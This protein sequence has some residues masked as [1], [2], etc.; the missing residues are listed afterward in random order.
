M[1]QADCLSPTCKLRSVFS[2]SPVAVSNTNKGPISLQI[3]GLTNGETVR[4]EKFLD[5]NRDGVLGVG[6]ELMQSFLLTD[7]QRSVIGGITNRN[8]P[9]DTTPVDGAIA[10]EVAFAGDVAQQLVG[11]YIF[12]L[13]SPTGRFLAI[14]RLF[15]VT[16]S[17]Y[18]QSFSGSVQCNGTN[19]PNVVVMVTPANSQKDSPVAGVV[20]DNSGHYSI[21]LPVGA[22][23]FFLFKSNFVAD[24]T[25]APTVDLGAGVSVSTNLTFLFPTTRTISGRVVDAG[26]SCLGLPGI[27]VFCQSAAS[28]IANGFTDAG[29]N[30]SVRVTSSQWKV[31][32]DD[33]GLSAYGYLRL[34]NNN[35][36]VDTSSGSVSGVTVALPK[37]TALVYGSVKDDQNRPIAGLKLYADDNNSQ[38]EGLGL[39]DQNGKY[40]VAVLASSWYVSPDNT[41][42]RNYIFTQG[43]SV[44][45]TSGQA[46]QQNFSGTIGTN[47]ISGLVQNTGN[48]PV[49]GVGVYGYATI[50]G[51]TYNQYM[52]TD[53]SGYYSLNV[54]NGNWNVGISCSGGND[55][56]GS[57][58]YQC[59][60]EQSATVANNNPKVNFT[61]QACASVQVTT[62]SQLP[63]GQVGSSYGVQFQAS[64]CN[65]PFSWAL[66]PGSQSLPAGMNLSSDGG[67]SGTPGVSGTFSFTVRVTSNT[68]EWADQPFSVT[69]NSSPLQVMTAS[70]P[71]GTSGQFY[72]QA[73]SASGGSPPYTWSLSPGSANPPPGLSLASSGQL[74]GTPTASGSYNFF[75]RVMDSAATTADQLLSLTINN[76]ALQVTN[77]NLPAATLGGVYSAQL[78]AIGGQPSY[79]WSL[80]LG[81]ANLPPG[82]SLDPS[83]LISGTPTTNGLFNFIVKVTDASFASVTRILGIQAN[84]QLTLG[85][86]FRPSPTQFQFQVNGTA[87]QNYTIQS[88]PDLMNWTLVGTTNSP[89]NIFTV[90]LNKSNNNQS[91]YRVMVG[92]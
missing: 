74:S 23:G 37:G 90:L 28:Q 51:V 70:L 8:V 44:A 24:L 54:A 4:A 91:Y 21:K 76:S 35:T 58:G 30:F 3:V 18:G 55:A 34:Q 49:V 22:Y 85:L 69:I 63:G 38:Y 13:S 5:A 77:T 11:Q 59:V 10:A 56:L 48:N 25:Q 75:V 43:N 31:E 72:S 9:G 61:V 15:N 45:L 39:S 1:L 60:S 73:F 53:G 29:G 17:A 89:G 87:G 81:S 27:F 2:V 66:A 14:T 68:G 20:A 6:D 64:G 12:K 62:S 46:M 33:S 52:Q 16:N 83:G 7:G 82:L 36:I 67:L 78:G 79:S 84:P 71:S 65:Q 19:V 88:S 92:Q 26:N 42:L 41:S 80:A 50:N 47:Q 86:A 57:Q 40:C 32:L